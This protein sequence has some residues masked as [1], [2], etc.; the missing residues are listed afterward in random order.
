MLPLSALTSLLSFHVRSSHA[1]GL[2]LDI[3]RLLG[4][5]GTQAYANHPLPSRRK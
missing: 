1:A 4:Y 2:E 5:I 3:S